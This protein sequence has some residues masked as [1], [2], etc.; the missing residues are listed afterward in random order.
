MIATDSSLFS[1]FEFDE[2][3]W[4]LAL[5]FRSTNEVRYYADFSPETFSEFEAA[6]S[7]GAFFNQHIKGKFEVV[8]AG[9]ISD[10][11]IQQ[12]VTETAA[13][14][15]VE[16]MT[17]EDPLGI[18]TADIRAVDPAYKDPRAAQPKEMEGT[19]HG[20]PLPGTKAEESIVETLAK[21]ENVAM[22]VPKAGRAELQ[23]LL[24]ESHG[25]IIAVKPITSVTEYTLVSERL[26][27]KVTV[28]DRL[29]NILDPVRK[30]LWDAL[31]VTR[32]QHGLILDPIDASI[33]ADKKALVQWSTEQQRI[34]A[35]AQRKA[36][37]EAEEEAA[38]EQRKRTEA[39]RMQIAEE[40][41]QAGDMEQAEVTLFDQTI[42]AAPVQV[43]APR[44]EVQVPVIEG[45]SM[46]KNWSGRVTDFDALVLDVAEGIK[47]LK[48]TNSLAGHAPITVLEVCQ[49]KLNQLAKAS[50][51]TLR[52]PGV[53][54]ENNP[55]MAQR[56]GK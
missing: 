53:V 42:Q 30:A 6:K 49:P 26:Q 34:A 46:R 8:P 28:R 23:S 13:P 35:E 11:E 15:P 47:S 45:Q 56:R 43:Y 24:D 48:A 31:T 44:V 16:G 39:L 14:I 18:T 17:D 22:S 40:Q 41:A 33:S 10:E 5:V 37:R 32:T 2:G 29:F 1:A 4:T 3:S 21:T 36:Q 25:L 9:K 54:A 51:A 27:K 50:E 38:A 7:K 19:W 52:I 12:A 20:V 55:V